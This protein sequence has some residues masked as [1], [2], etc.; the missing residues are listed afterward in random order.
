VPMMMMIVSTVH[1]MNNTGFVV[2]SVEE[3]CE[4]NLVR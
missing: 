4:R 3:L 1:R 2:F